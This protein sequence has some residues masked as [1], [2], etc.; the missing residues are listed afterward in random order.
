MGWTPH[1]QPLP[2]QQPGSSLYSTGAAPA[3]QPAG[4]G[5][6]PRGGSHWVRNVLTVIGALVVAGVVVSILS[7]IG[8]GGSSGTTDTAGNSS[9]CTTNS[10]IAADA[11]TLKG[12]VA[13]DN[14]VMTKV[15][16]REVT[17]KQVVSGTYTVH[18]TA[19]YSDGSVWGGIA[20]VLTA[21]GNIEWEATNMISQGSG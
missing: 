10:C 16:C 9:N 13:K 2:G 20:S 1:T 5:A 18:C 12:T 8:S 19:T 7:H 3:P 4:S 17:V 21:Q 6:R 11:E 15:T 14:S